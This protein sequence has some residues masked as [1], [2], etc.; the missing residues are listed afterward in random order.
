MNLIALATLNVYITLEFRALQILCSYKSRVLG[1]KSY[2]LYIEKIDK[3]YKPYM[4]YKCSFSQ[5]DHFLTNLECF[6]DVQTID[7]ELP[8]MSEIVS[9][10]CVVH[11]QNNTLI[12]CAS[13]ERAIAV[14]DS[15][16]LGY[17][18]IC[19]Y[20]LDGQYVY[21]NQVYR[22]SQEVYMSLENMYKA[23]H[24]FTMDDLDWYT[25][26]NLISDITEGYLSYSHKPDK[27]Y[28]VKV[29]IKAVSFYSTDKPVI[30]VKPS[31]S[32][33]VLNYLTRFEILC[34]KALMFYA[35]M[36]NWFYDYQIMNFN[37]IIYDYDKTELRLT[38]IFA[39]T[40]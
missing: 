14:C 17:Y 40:D 20:W 9:S 18:V 2:D 29:Y 5:F 32:M 10:Y 26:T 1:F 30:I 13:F 38:P 33:M 37:S 3:L 34:I 12:E 4:V 15:M 22:T 39:L 8:V 7:L 24:M 19:K 28:K 6:D 27:L 16:G 35:Q 31:F 25:L 23:L 36:F 21:D 11:V